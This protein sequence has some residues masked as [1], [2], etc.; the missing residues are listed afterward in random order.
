MTWIIAVT[1]IKGFI[2]RRVVASLVKIPDAELVRIVRPDTDPMPKAG[3]KVITGD[4][5]D[6]S[7]THQ[8][9]DAHADVLVRLA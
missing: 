3:Y 1:G 6:E 8:L 4:V 5:L 9:G 7:A 2:G